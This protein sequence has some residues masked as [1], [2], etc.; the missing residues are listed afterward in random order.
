[1][2]RR[3]VDPA[4]LD[5]VMEL[6]SNAAVRIVVAGAGVTAISRLVVADKLAA[7]RG[8]SVPIT[9]P[10]VATWRCARATV[11]PGGIG[12]SRHDEDSLAN[13]RHQSVGQAPLAATAGAGSLRRVIQR[14]SRPDPFTPGILRV[15]VIPTIRLIADTLNEFCALVQSRS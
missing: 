2:R 6:P 5:V 7:G 15:D 8:R 11:F 10:I 12:S 13:I 4:Q 3:G 1:L 14:R 9:A